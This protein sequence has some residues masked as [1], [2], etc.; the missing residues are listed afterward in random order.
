MCSKKGI[1]KKIK[2]EGHF[3]VEDDIMFQNQEELNLTKKQKIKRLR[4]S[5]KNMEWVINA[6]K[7]DLKRLLE[8]GND[9]NNLNKKNHY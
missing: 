2:K 4:D 8:G 5:I 1:R 9:G 6:F 3:Y 7:K